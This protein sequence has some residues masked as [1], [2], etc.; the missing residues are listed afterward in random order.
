VH[1]PVDC[2][3]FPRWIN[4]VEVEDEQVCFAAV[5]ARVAGHVLPNLGH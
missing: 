5:D 3:A 4:M 1:K 2:L